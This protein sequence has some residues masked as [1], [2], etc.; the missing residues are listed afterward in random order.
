MNPSILEVRDLGVAFGDAAAVRGIDLAVAPGEVLGLVGESG[1][2]KSVAMR[3]VM[4]LLPATARVAGSVR[5]LGDELIG[6]PRRHLRSLRGA[7]MAMIFQD[8]MTALN[9]VLPIG[10]QIAEAITIHDRAITASARRR[11]AH[12]LLDLVAMPAAEASLRKFPFELS[13]G[14]RQRVV[15]AIAM[16]NNPD[17]LIADE[18]TT[19]LDVTV[20]A[21]ILEL[22]RRLRDHR[23][24]GMVLIT[25]DFGVIAGLADRVAVMYAGRIVE[26]GPV[27]QLFDHPGHPYTRGLLA[28][29]PH[30]AGGVVTGIEGIPPAPGA[31]PPGCPFAPRCMHAGPPCHADEPKLLPSRGTLAACHF[32]T[33]HV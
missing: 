32:A 12:E 27:D 3:A 31:L 6:Q 11:R 15:I 1:S 28:A 7:H 21:Q 29:T 13:G 4:G 17:L 2:G 24:M 8:P 19:A 25:H 5:L 26:T 14:M 10:A 22:L 23:R 30:I 9:P 18:P 33:A 16:A 20:Q